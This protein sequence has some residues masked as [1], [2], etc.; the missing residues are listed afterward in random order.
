[1]QDSISYSQNP[2]R[3]S[4]LSPFLKMHTGE[5]PGDP[6]VKTQCFHCRGP[7]LTPGWGTK[8]LHSMGCSQKK[9]KMKIKTLR[10]FSNLPQAPEAA[11]DW[12]ENCCQG[13]LNLHQHHTS[14]QSSEKN[15]AAVKM[16]TI[17]THSCAWGLGHP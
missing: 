2:T 9:K 6:M 8:I 1:M 10:Q 15:R 14:P 11:K 7:S 3:K 17:R 4:F 16:T 13:F 12:V 5:F